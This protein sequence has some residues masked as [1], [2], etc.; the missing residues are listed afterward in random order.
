MRWGSSP[1]DSL[2]PMP[3]SITKKKGKWMV[4]KKKKKKIGDESKK[5][6]NEAWWSHFIF[7]LT[8]LYSIS[9]FTR[10]NFERYIDFK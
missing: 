6:K 4:P 5:E 2:F 9:N 1:L 8:D 7:L 3:N 10:D